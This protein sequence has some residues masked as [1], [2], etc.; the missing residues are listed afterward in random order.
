MPP[1]IT[2]LPVLLSLEVRGDS[3]G[4]LSSCLVAD[5]GGSAGPHLRAEVD[6]EEV[7]VHQALAHHVVKDGD[8][9][10]R[11]DAGE[12]QPQDAVKGVVGQKGARLLLAEADGLVADLDVSNLGREKKG[13]RCAAFWKNTRFAPKESGQ[14]SGALPAC[15]VLAWEP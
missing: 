11:G 6:G 13:T 5:R 3:R 14:P 9:P 4:M 8:G 1:S 15:S 2:K 7:L 12:G 10:R